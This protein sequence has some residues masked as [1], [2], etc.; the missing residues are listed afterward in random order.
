MSAVHDHLE[1]EEGA[2]LADEQ[3][4]YDLDGNDG[5]PADLSS[6]YTAQARFADAAGTTDLLT[7]NSGDGITLAN[8]YLEL[9]LTPAQTSAL[10]AALVGSD[11]GKF[12]IDLTRTSDNF[13]ERLIDGTFTLYRQAA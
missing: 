1:I 4:R 2:S 11:R 8:G 12:Q 13:V 7:I 9:V 3:A 6:G 5:Y 10:A